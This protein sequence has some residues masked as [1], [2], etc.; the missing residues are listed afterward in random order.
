MTWPMVDRIDPPL[1]TVRIQQY[2]VGAAAGELLVERM[3]RRSE[4]NRPQHI[5]MPVELVV[6]GSTAPPAHR[7]AALAQGKT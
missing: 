5:V 1:T 6:R 4:I 7:W 2:R 3:T